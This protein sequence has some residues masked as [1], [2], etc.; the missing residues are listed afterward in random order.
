[1][2][3]LTEIDTQ[4]AS[5]AFITD[6]YPTYH[7]LRESAPV[8]RSELWQCWVLTRYHD[9]SD[10]LRDTQRFSN[11]GRFAR[12]LDQ[13]PTGMNDI[14]RPLREHY[15]SGIL[16]CDP[17]DH[18]RIR[19]LVSRA[20][21]P[22][23][24]REAEPQIEALIADLIQQGLDAGQFD[25][26]ADFAKPLPAM[27]ISD[28]LGVPP[29][30]RARFMP[31]GDDLTG[32]QAAGGA[33]ATAAQRAA[34]AVLGLE[35]YFR[36]LY[37]ERRREPRD[38]LLSALVAAHDGEDRLSE[39]ELVNTCVTILV[40]GHE[41]TRNLIGNAAVTFSRHEAAWRDLE[42]DPAAL[43]KAVDEILRYESPI[44]RGWR[45]IAADTEFHGQAM[46][47]DDLLFLMLGSA[48]RDPRRFAQ[49]DELDL[50]REDNP[51]LAFARGPHFCLGAPL[52]R[53]EARI[54][55]A[56]LRRTFKRLQ[57]LREPE[58]NPSIHMRGVSSFDV[59]LRWAAA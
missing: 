41:T 29:S 23:A 19:G 46:K 13:L 3:A 55:L 5:A 52:A 22:K 43:A 34:D 26:V 14:L 10:A 45:R 31:L 44:Q 38:D 53:L 20:F 18:A 17:P 47:E 21:T 36:S 11:A 50:Q 9:I 32:L 37:H 15:S 59:D 39:N 42:T 54:A 58:W 24:V 8:F 33:A 51:H 6:P 2:S 48:N 56:G 57:P 12:L 40:A 25:L 27:V 4:L 35:E 49:P 7:E 30:D 1:L 16:Q 28:M